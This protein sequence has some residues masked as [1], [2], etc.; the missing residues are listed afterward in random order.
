M[1]AMLFASTVFAV[2]LLG[3]TGGHGQDRIED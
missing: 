2:S 3:F 1:N